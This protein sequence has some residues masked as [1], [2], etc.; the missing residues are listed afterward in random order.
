MNATYEVAVK[1]VNGR[2]SRVDWINAQL[3]FRV[4]ERI[5]YMSDPGPRGQCNV[6][7][8]RWRVRREWRAVVYYGWISADGTTH[9]ENQKVRYG[10]WR[11]KPDARA[12]A[13]EMALDILYDHPSAKYSSAD[14]IRLP[15]QYEQAH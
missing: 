2:P 12:E 7:V 15:A 11:S 6:L 4:G 9:A 8:K 5:P 14:G 1:L 3:I 13:R 10:D